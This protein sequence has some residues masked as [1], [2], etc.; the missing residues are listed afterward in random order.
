MPDLFDTAGTSSSTN[1]STPPPTKDLFDVA[2][3]SPAPVAASQPRD[4]FDVASPA[5]R[6]VNVAK[7]GPYAT[8]LSSDDEQDFQQWI[9]A[10][11]VPWKDSPTADYDMR[12]YWKA[13]QSGDAQAKTEVNAVDHLPHYPDTWKT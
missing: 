11:K 12:G 13:Q 3:P 9:K 1:P 8:P 7:P 2:A 10:N 4:L 5:P 6:W